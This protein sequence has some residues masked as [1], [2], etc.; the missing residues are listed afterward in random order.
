[1]PVDEVWVETEPLAGSAALC[2]QIGPED[3]FDVEVIEEAGMVGLD[4]RLS[5]GALG[6][7]SKVW[8]LDG[9]A[10]PKLVLL[11]LPS[12]PRGPASRRQ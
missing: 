2:P 6:L 5:R 9:D 4:D 11:E 10:E 7:A 12:M 3:G 8:V 1:M